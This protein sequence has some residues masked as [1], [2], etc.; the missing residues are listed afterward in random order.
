[1]KTTKF[2]IIAYWFVLLLILLAFSCGT[3]TKNKTELETEKKGREEFQAFDSV[4]KMEEF[5]LAKFEENKKNSE[6]KVTE[7]DNSEELETTV[8]EVLTIESKDSFYYISDDRKLELK[9]GLI[10]ATKTTKTAKKDTKKEKELLFEQA[11]KN[12]QKIDSANNVINTQ[13]IGIKAGKEYIEKERSKG[14]IVE[15]KGWKP[16]FWFWVKF[17]TIS[18]LLLL[19]LL[20]YF[21]RKWIGRLYPPL[22]FFKFFRPETT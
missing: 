15:D 14:K 13:N 19:L 5:L 21:F 16:S 12:Q 1:M 6:L 3:K 20:V 2:K 10:T 18:L 17:G 22:Q 11:E 8:T 9:S 4:K 7:T